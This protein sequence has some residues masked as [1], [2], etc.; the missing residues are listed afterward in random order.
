MGSSFS[1]CLSEREC[2]LLAEETRLPRELIVRFAEM[3]SA[4]EPPHFKKVSD[5]GTLSP[6]DLAELVRGLKVT[7]PLLCRSIARVI[8]EGGTATFAQ[9]VRGYGGLHSRTLRE[10]LPF[11]FRVF[12][13]DGDGRLKQEEF[14]A[15]LDETMAMQQL[16]AAQ[17]KKVLRTPRADEERVE[18]ISFDSFRYFASLSGQVRPQ[19]QR[20]G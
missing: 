12:D 18:G 4:R 9:F 17:I 3:W 6:V 13:M 7:S 5:D 11:A 20:I 8:G 10:A 15:V 2:A 19:G 1:S 14:M 16:D